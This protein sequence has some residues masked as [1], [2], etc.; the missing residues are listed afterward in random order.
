MAHTQAGT[1]MTVL[2]V[3][4]NA[5]NQMIGQKMLLRLGCAVVLANDV[6]GGIAVV[7]LVRH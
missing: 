5:L 4:D 3:E 2:L 1:G 7:A 6:S